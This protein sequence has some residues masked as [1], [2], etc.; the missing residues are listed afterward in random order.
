MPT[1]GRVTGRA[2]W[3]EI[4]FFDRNTFF[5]FEFFA[6]HHIE[7]TK[8]YLGYVRNRKKPVE[9]LFHIIPLLFI[10][11]EAMRHIYIHVI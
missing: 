8:K 7:T 5:Y 11:H 2:Q 4:D 1:V 10:M 3:L 6:Y 9:F